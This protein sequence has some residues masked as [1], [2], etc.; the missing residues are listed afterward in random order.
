[1]VNE[2]EKDKD[3]YEVEMKFGISYHKYGFHGFHYLVNI[4]LFYTLLDF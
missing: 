3:F 4:Q 2:G 1:M